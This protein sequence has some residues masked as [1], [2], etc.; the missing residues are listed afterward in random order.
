MNF[1]K[2][3]IGAGVFCDT[4]FVA[5][6]ENEKFKPTAS[7][8]YYIPSVNKWVIGPQFIQRR[9][10]HSLVCCNKYLYALGGNDERK[11][12]TSVEMLDD[13]KGVWQNI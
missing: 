7:C 2:Y 4:L 6:G 9:E 5:G 1:C 11:C 8:E 10:K 12:L 13:L 3:H